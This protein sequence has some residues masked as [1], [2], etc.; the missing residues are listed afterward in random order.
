MGAESGPVAVD[1]VFERFPA[2]VRGA[3][4]V[5]G[6]DREPHQVRVEG[7]DVVEAHATNRSVRPASVTSATVDVP[8]RGEILVPVEVPFAG[9]DPGWYCVLADVVVDGSLRMR[10]PE[11]G[12]KRFL[13]PWPSSEVRRGEIRADL[14]I[15]V[16]GSDAVKVE[17]VECKADRAIVRWRH[18][19]GENPD[20]GTLKVLAGRRRLPELET[21]ADPETGTRT[22]IVHPVPKTAERLVFELDRRGRGGRSKR[23]PRAVELDLR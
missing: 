4:V 3:V 12:G 5:R 9:L 6:Q 1:L 8:P 10:G 18:A 16:P 15:S 14:T 19:P 11:G 23:G 2:S 17:Q 7:A 21:A 22:T 13:V 20:F